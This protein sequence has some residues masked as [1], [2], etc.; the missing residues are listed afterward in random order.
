VHVPTNE[1][2]VSLNLHRYIPVQLPVY[3][4]G[5]DKGAVIERGTC[6]NVSGGGGCTSC[7][8]S[9]PVAWNVCLTCQACI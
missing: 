5:G 6:E 1:K 9:C 7:E 4:P 3:N 8:R 2:A